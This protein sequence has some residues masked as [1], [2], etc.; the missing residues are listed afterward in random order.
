MMSTHNATIANELKAL[1]AELIPAPLPGDR[2]FELWASVFGE[3]VAR[4]GLMKLSL[5]FKKLSG[6]MDQDYQIKFASSVMNSRM[7]EL[8]RKEPGVTI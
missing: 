6:Q 1:W 8:M 2:Q 5:K 4:L 7:R 3:D